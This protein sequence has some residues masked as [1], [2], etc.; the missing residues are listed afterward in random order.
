MDG[1]KGGQQ[2]V[3]RLDAQPT[4]RSSRQKRQHSPPL[5]NRPIEPDQKVEIAPFCLVVIN[6][7]DKQPNLRLRAE[8]FGRCRPSH[9][10]LI[11]VLM[12]IFVES[13]A[14]VIMPA[15]QRYRWRAGWMIN[16]IF[17]LI[18]RCHQL[19]SRTMSYGAASGLATCISIR[20]WN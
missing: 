5:F 4:L 20:R 12:L 11:L 16:S 18:S 19:Y 7:G 9:L 8:K 13:H 17:I 10:L 6:S 14:F 15:H 1:G 3:D 2:H